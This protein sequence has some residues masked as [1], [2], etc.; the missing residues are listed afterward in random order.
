MTPA[1][2][3]EEVL[4]IVGK[5]NSKNGVKIAVFSTSSCELLPESIKN[6][7]VPE[8]K[9]FI[10][11]EIKTVT[12]NPKTN[13]IPSRGMAESATAIKLKSKKGN[14]KTSNS[15]KPALIVRKNLMVSGDNAE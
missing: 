14:T 8:S 5:F 2:N 1:S 6:P 10:K 7:T 3:A 15:R 13:S 12:I 9:I 4:A 11:L